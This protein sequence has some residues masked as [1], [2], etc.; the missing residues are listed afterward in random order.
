MSS[1]HICG[2][3][4]ILYEEGLVDQLFCNGFLTHPGDHGRGYSF[5]LNRFRSQ[6]SLTIMAVMICRLTVHFS[7]SFFMD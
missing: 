7:T 6:A 3:G 4:Y 1:F 2:H 5:F